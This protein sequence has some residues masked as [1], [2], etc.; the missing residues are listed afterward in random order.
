[1]NKCYIPMT[2][3]SSREVFGL[4]RHLEYPGNKTGL[5]TRLQNV[6]LPSFGNFCTINANLWI[7]DDLS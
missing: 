1:M 3:V 6:Q 5:C 4:L 2:T 7:N